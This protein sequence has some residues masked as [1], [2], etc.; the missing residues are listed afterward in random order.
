MAR[1]RRVRV[2]FKPGTSAVPTLEGATEVRRSGT[3]KVIAG[4]YRVEFPKVIVD[5][6]DSS[7]SDSVMEI[8]AANVA[9]VEV[10]SL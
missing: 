2:H 7:T 6:N 4:H 1:K 10:L 8:P 5:V 3:P 9:I